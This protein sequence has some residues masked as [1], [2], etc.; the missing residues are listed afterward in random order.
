MQASIQPGGLTFYMSSDYK[1]RSDYVFMTN[2][3]LVPYNYTSARDSIF[4]SII[5]WDGLSYEYLKF[6]LLGFSPTTLLYFLER[7]LTSLETWLLWTKN[8][9]I[10]VGLQG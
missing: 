1:N 5:N 6:G 4:T 9:S 3:L 10:A 8:G 2:F 7:Q